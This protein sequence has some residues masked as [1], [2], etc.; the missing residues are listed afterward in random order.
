MLAAQAEASIDGIVIVDARD[1][2]VYANQRFAELWGFPAGSTLTGPMDPV[3]Q[4]VLEQVADPDDY[5][6]KLRHLHQHPEETRLGEVALRDGRVFDGYCTPV[7]GP[8]GGPGGRVWFFHDITR[9]ARAEAKLLESRQSLEAIINSIADPVF[10]KDAEHRFILVNEAFCAVIGAPPEA[11]LGKQ[12]A[13][14]FPPEQ[15]DVFLRQDSLVFA[16][17]IPNVN[18]EVISRAD[19]ALLTIVT[20]KTLHTDAVGRTVI[21]GVIRD[22]TEQVRAR[23]VQQAAQLRAQAL[24][25]LFRLP[26]TSDAALAAFALDQL[27]ALTESRLGFIGFVDPAE[28]TM[29][30]HVWSARAMQES[31]VE[32]GPTLFDVRTGGLW[33]APVREHRTVRVNDYAAPNPLKKGCPAGHVELTRFLG[34]PLGKEGRAVLVAGL[35][36]KAAE[37]GESDEAGAAL[38]LE[39]V[40]ELIGRNRAERGLIESRAQLDDVGAMGRVGGWELDVATKTLRWTGETYR[41]HDVPESESPDLATAILF[42]DLPGRSV[43]EAAVQSGLEEGKPFDLELPITSA[44][45]RRLWTRAMGYPVKA[46]GRVVK[47]TGTFQDITARKRAEERIAS[48]AA[49]VE[50][51]ADDSIVMDL[52]GRIQYV[53]SAFE[54]TSG[55]SSEE[56]VGRDIGH[57]LRRGA[58]E[59]AI[60]GLWKTVREGHPWQGRLSNRTRDGRAI[61]LD[62]SVSAI[63]DQSGGVIGYVSTRRDVT[64][65]VALEAHVVHA[66]KLEAVGTLA[67]GIAHDFNNI[68]SA[69]VGNTQMAMMKC[70]DATPVQQDLEVVLQAARRATDLVKQILTFSR[71]TLHEESPVELGLIVKEAMKLLR[72]TVP[73]TIE[74]RTDVRSTAM[75]LA[76][77]TEVHRSIVNLCTN[78]IV[79]MDGRGGVLEVG[80]A[81]VDVDAPLAQ[82]L[83]GTTPGSFVRLRIH[84]TG[85]GMSPEVLERIFEP[86]FTTREPGKGTGMGLAVV[87]GIV[88]SLHGA[89]TVTS[90][91]GE[92]TTFE[93]YLPV[94]PS[95]SQDGVVPLEEI[96][97][98]TERVLVVDDEPLVLETVGDMLHLLGYQVRSETSGAEALAA[99]EADPR[100]FDLVITDMTMPGMTGDVLAERLK[101]C[102]PDIPVILCSGYTEEQIPAGTRLQGID[103]FLMKPLFIGPLSQVLRQVLATRTEPVGEREAPAACPAVAT[104]P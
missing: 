80:L 33:A 26:R 91:P 60:P 50:Q 52:A 78:A 59:A 20:K 42:Y 103:E 6:A 39:G 11:I 5:R 57:F 31:A 65:Q 23:R 79:A 97:R 48:L 9:R 15:V 18:E 85:H 43:L 55:Y 51:S 99:F 74:I 49:A 40:W 4:R 30:A 2:I 96:R 86:F 34:G 45:G 29:S 92:G 90:E 88:T 63:R 61:V 36:N 93:I 53:N 73:T 14:F 98:G 76:D 75:V 70:P 8:N 47:L 84:D 71:H 41:I 94:A 81:D 7:F 46:D 25:E 12:D 32:D 58:N 69:I 100:A 27:V 56:A 35:G 24:L 44:R 54:R 102:R 87:H 19:G 72:A 67:G 89:I 17:G 101:G 66:D 77:P 28:A 62:C 22:I 16:T 37:Y 1:Q 83:L 13:D 3:V 104:Q 38:F 64:R 10:V 95:A 82:R 21:V 68:L